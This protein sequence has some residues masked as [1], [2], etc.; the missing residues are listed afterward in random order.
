MLETVLTLEFWV[1]LLESFQ[2]L[3]LLVPV[4]LVM[5]EALL[6][7]LPLIAIV[8][9]NVT[10]HGVVAGFLTSWIGSV[11]GSIIVF[12]LSRRILRKWYIKTFANRK[13]R[14][15]KWV[16]R[17]GFMELFLLTCVAFTPSSLIN[18]VYG[19]SQFDEKLFYKTIL[20]S[21]FIMILVL[22]LFGGSIAQ[23]Y[24]KPGFLF[25][26]ALIL[27]LLLLVTYIIKRRTGFEDANN[28][29]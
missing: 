8:V 24:E 10:A 2:S 12:N 15:M 3:G 4:V 9:L 20:F 22:A 19:C 27:G 28:E 21:K 18:I 25:I 5:I 7:A 13:Q 11:I 14:L 16:N 17:S 1:S 29:F 26:S 23:A 6:P